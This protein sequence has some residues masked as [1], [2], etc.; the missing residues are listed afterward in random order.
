MLLAIDFD[1]VIHDKAN[2][3][4]GRRMG[5]P[6][7]GARDALIKLRDDGHKVTIFTTMAVSVHGKNAVQDWM[8]YYDIPYWLVTATK[9]NAVIFVDDKAIR[10]TTWPNTLELIDAILGISEE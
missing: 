2:P 3:I 4:K 9:P 7:P 6:L 8:D 5:A 1:G 10:H